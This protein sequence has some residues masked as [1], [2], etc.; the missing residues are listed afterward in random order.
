MFFF[1]AAVNNRVQIVKL[2]GSISKSFVNHTTVHSQT[3]LVLAAEKGHIN[4]VKELLSQK[5]DFKIADDR[6]KTVLHYGIQF[7]ALLK[8]LLDVSYQQ[9]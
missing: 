5:A 8:V 2:L 3:A 1:R 9:F 7:P 4:V 6:G